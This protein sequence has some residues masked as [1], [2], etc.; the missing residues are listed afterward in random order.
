MA[1][2]PRYRI[3][4]VAQLITQ[5]GN[6]QQD[7]FFSEQDYLYYLHILNDAAIKYECHIHAFV[8]LS[9]Q[10]HILATPTTLDGISQLMKSVGQ[11][12]VSYINKLEKRSGTL[13]GG[14]Y[15]ASLV[16]NGNYILNCMRYIE[17]APVRLNIVASPIKYKW[18]SYSVNAQGDEVAV[19]ITPHNSYR[20]V[21]SWSVKSD[22]DIQQVYKQLVR[23]ELDEQKLKTNQQA[24]NR[25]LIIGS[26][27]F[28]ASIK[29][30]GSD[31]K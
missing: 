16:E 30:L 17:T 26:D 9:N 7:V 25:C 29:K 3:T 5:C 4:D 14:R 2:Q 11:R 28:K 10:I 8:L 23:E 21:V 19:L 15:K 6:N 12:Y 20:E 22:K 31:P 1:R 13:W 18:S 27:E 24:T